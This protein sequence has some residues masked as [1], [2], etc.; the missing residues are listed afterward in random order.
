[1][2]KNLAGDSGFG[3]TRRELVQQILAPQPAVPPFREL[4]KVM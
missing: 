4:S 2:Q 1:M 3:S